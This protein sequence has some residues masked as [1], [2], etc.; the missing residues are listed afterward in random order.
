MPRLKN[1]WTSDIKLNLKLRLYKTLC[2]SIFFYGAESWIAHTQK[3][4][5]LVNTLHTRCLRRTCNIK[6]TDRVSNESIYQITKE[7]PL[8]AQLRSRQLKWLGH[9]LRHP[10][11]AAYNN[12]L[13]L[14]QTTARLSKETATQN[15]IL[16]DDHTPSGGYNCWRGQR[17]RYR[18]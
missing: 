13:L 8:I 3:H 12:C 14:E 5:A 10:I 15:D 2:L 7:K 16:Q 18:P 9:R 17:S 4:R 1:I 11:S 6:Y